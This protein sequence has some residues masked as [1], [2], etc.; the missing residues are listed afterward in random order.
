MQIACKS[1][2]KED[3]MIDIVSLC[4][5][6][7]R[8]TGNYM[9]SLCTTQFCHLIHDFPRAKIVHAINLNDGFYFQINQLPVHK[10]AIRSVGITM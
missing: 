6:A 1:I 7:A 9:E 3:L 10:F 5:S 4:T 2:P 8:A